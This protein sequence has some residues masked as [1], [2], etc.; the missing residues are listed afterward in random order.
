MSR[1]SVVRSFAVLL[2]VSFCSFAEQIDFSGAVTHGETFRKQIGH[3]LFFV[4]RPDDVGY[5]IAIE[6]A[7]GAKEDFSDC[8]TPP[9]HGPN[10]KMLLVR[11]LRGGNGKPLPNDEVDGLKKREFTFVLNAADNKKACAETQ[12]ALYG[13][14]KKDKNGTPVLGF[15]DYK[16]PPLGNGTFHLRTFEADEPEHP[17]R[18]KSLTFTVHLEFPKPPRKNHR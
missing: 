3:G 5:T 18:F 8:V 15:L 16:Q 2:L 14:E 10:P 12:E 13:P 7:S 17:E 9:F 4:L 11:D 1:R 6:P